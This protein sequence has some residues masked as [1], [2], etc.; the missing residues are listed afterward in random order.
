[1][2]TVVDATLPTDQFVLEETIDRVRDVEFAPV[3][4]A[5]GS[6]TSPM[7]FL[8]GSTRHPDR[9]EAALQDDPSTARVQC[10][11]SDDSRNLYSVD[12]TERAAGLIERFVGTGGAVLDVRGASDRWTFRI[13]FPD[14]ATA[15]ETFQ[16]WRDDGVAPSI[17]RISNL[18]SREADRGGLSPTQHN[19]IVHA[20]RTDYYSV[21]RG[22]TLEGLATHFDVS[23]QALSERL[24]RG[25]SRLVE[26]MLSGSTAPVVHG[27]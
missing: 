15:S 14:R 20:F 13:L 22:T 1:M 24:R 10:L 23:H 3:R 9:L 27:P 21:P 2:E 4:F 17:S 25:H 16:T 7:P 19:T 26:R 12:W 5:V 11:S 18:S 6:S 8:R